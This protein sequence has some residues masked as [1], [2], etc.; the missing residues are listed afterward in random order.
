MTEQEAIE[1]AKK[2]A[3]DQGWAWVEP[4]RAEHGRPWF[5]KGGWW[6]IRDNDS[7]RGRKVYIKIDD[8]TGAII[9]KQLIG[10]VE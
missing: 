5:G 7:T 8:L 10:G 3:E 2:V 9:E 6:E 1:I 4:V